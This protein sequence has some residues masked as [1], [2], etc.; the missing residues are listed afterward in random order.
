MDLGVDADTIIR[1][2]LIVPCTAILPPSVSF[3]GQ[4]VLI[5]VQG[6]PAEQRGPLF[7]GFDSRYEL[8]YCTADEWA[9]LQPRL[10]A[11][12]A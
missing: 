7:S 5:D 10:T 11:L 12:G 8:F 6:S 2:Q 9:E 1:G 3:S 4:F